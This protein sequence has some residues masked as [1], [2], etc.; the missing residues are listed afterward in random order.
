[1]AAVQ[2]GTGFYEVTFPTNVTACVP[3]VSPGNN[4]SNGLA[5][6][7][8]TYARMVNDEGLTGQPDTVEVDVLTPSGTTTNSAFNLIVMC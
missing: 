7:A 6:G 4:S 2:K 5:A 1:M 3:E 8:I